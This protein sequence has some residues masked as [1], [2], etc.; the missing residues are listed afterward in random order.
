LPHERGA[1]RWLVSQFTAASP[2]DECIAVSA[3]S[4]PIGIWNRYAFQLSS[5][6]FPDYPHLG[7]WPDGYYITTYEFAGGSTYAGPEAF[8]FDRAK[9]LAGQTANFQTFAPLGSSAN[10][11]LPADFDGRILPPVGAPNTFVGFGGSLTLF[12]FHVDQSL[13]PRTRQG[14]RQ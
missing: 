1:G 3:T 10:P 7:V 11:M 6:N 13:W 9:M 8:V 4:D 14:H 12:Q 2:Y 5:T